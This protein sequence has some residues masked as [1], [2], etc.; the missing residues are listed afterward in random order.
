M[1]EDSAIS[2]TLSETR[3]F[4]PARSFAE[5]A[6][7]NS[8]DE[9]RTMYERSIR[10]PEEFWA[11]IAEQHHWFEKWRTVRD[12]QRPDVKWFVGGK[13]NLAYNCLDLQID[14]G[15]GDHPAILWEGEPG[16]G[17]TLTYRQLKSEVCK[18][19][20]ALKKLGV[21]KGDCVTIYMPMCPCCGR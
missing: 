14:R 10:Q 12:W 21:R 18:F 1:S 13:T 4:P 9:Y 11:E 2:S 16:D 15:R 6:N 7:I 19:A 8:L 3:R 17:R 20:G 5:A